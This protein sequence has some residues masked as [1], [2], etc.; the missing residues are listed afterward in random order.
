MT[1]Q[2]STPW[3]D[4]RTARAAKLQSDG[5]SA[6][7]IA[8]ELGGVSR[9][10]VIGKLVRMGLAGKYARSPGGER[11]PLIWDRNERRRKRRAAAAAIAA[12][13]PAERRGQQIN[14]ERRQTSRRES[15]SPKNQNER[16]KAAEKLRAQFACTEIVELTPE[17]SA[18]ACTLMELTRKTCR[19]PI[20]NTTTPATMRFCGAEPRD[21]RPYCAHH[22]KIAYRGFSA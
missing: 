18:T 11:P 6:G 16:E 14:F 17:Q 3:S 9:N 22:C 7:M 20:D 13:Q 5:M 21:G 19:W 10:A 4:E 1:N 15:Y 2:F 12:T 8:A